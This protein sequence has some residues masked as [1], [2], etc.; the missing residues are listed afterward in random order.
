MIRT[1]QSA[2]SHIGGSIRD[3]AK[4]HPVVAVLKNSVNAV[5]EVA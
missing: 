4:A 2:V 3:Q 1:I 5:E